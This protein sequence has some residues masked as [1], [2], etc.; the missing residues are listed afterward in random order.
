[1]EVFSL[2]TGDRWAA[3]CF[4]SNRKERDALITAVC[5]YKNDRRGTAQLLVAMTTLGHR[6]SG[7]LLGP[8]TSEGLVCL[9]DLRT[10]SVVKAV[11]IPYEVSSYSDANL[12]FI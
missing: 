2:R 10:S 5:E 11:E 4:G 12:S 7:G 3:W 1:M 8:R 9:F 6:T